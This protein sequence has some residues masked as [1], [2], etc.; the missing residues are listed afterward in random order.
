MCIRDSVAIEQIIGLIRPEGT[1][2]LMGVS[3]YPVAVNTRMV[4]EKLSLIHI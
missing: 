1:I 2:S 3:E 4:L